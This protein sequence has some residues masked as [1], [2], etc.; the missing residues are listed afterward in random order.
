MT[1]KRKA[2]SI[3]AEI[4]LRLRRIR[5]DRKLSQEELGEK[6][7]VSYQQI[8]KYETGANR[9]SA[10]NLWLLAR[11]LN[12]GVMEIMPSEDFQLP[13]A[14]TEIRTVEPRLTERA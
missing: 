5:L 11:C 9:V 12:C 10:G 3:D 7:G 2:N 6:I 4:G 13:S 1:L 14:D 8:Q